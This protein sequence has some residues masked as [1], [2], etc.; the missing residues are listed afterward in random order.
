MRSFSVFFAAT[1]CTVSYAQSTQ[2]VLGSADLFGN[3]YQCN[4][5]KQT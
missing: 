4:N 3:S 1:L 5:G 2:H